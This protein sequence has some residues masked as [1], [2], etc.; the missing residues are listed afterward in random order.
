MGRIEKHCAYRDGN[1]KC[2]NEAEAKHRN[3]QALC[4]GK[5][6]KYECI[7][8]VKT[9]HDAAAHDRELTP[10][11][12]GLVRLYRGEGLTVLQIAMILDRSTGTIEEILAEE[13]KEE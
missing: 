2:V 13:E 10:I 1:G 4:R 3:K 9:R 6:R 11:T 5:C 7:S 8:K 12:R